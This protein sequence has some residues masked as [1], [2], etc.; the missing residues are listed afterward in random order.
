MIQKAQVINKTT[1]VHVHSLHKKPL[2]PSL[3][4]ESINSEDLLHCVV[5]DAVGCGVGKH[6]RRQGLRQFKELAVL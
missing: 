5:D 1:R 4:H 6:V 2:C 3:T